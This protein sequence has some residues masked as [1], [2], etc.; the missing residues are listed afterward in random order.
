MDRSRPSSDAEIDVVPKK[1][2]SS[3]TNMP[4]HDCNKNYP[5]PKQYLVNSGHKLTSNEKADKSMC[6]YTHIVDK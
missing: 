6:N 1:I 5:P 2:Q 4:W 3:T